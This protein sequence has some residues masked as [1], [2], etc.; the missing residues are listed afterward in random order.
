MRK[1]D[2][3]GGTKIMEIVVPNIVAS[4]QHEQQLTATPTAL[5]I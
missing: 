2:D 3:G 4:Q 5:A 1:V